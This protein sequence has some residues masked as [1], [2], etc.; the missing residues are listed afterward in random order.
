MIANNKYHIFSDKG[1]R[2]TN[3]DVELVKINLTSAGY[4]DDQNFAPADF[5][6]VCDGHGGSEVAKC[7]APLLLKC[8]M[9]SKKTYPLEDQYIMRVC[10]GIQNS[11]IKHSGKIAEHC[12]STALVVILYID[13]NKKRQLQIINIGDCRAVLS[14][15]CMAIPLTSDHKPS[16]PK[17][18]ERIR[19]VNL[20]YK[21]NERI[22]FSEGDFR[23]GDLSVSRSF[24][25]IDNTPYV[26]HIPDIYDCALCPNDEFLIMACDGVWDVL[27]SEEA[28]HFVYDHYNDNS[29]NL[30]NIP[31]LYPPETPYRTKNIAEKL[32]HYALARG[33]QDNISVIIIFFG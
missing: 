5:F 21:T 7:V 9:N 31:G 27:G 3:E 6:V 33:S 25:D 18:K 23:I 10:H 32:A 26:T 14:R 17:E 13:A 12:G 4:R 28:V 19:R 29:T 11:L 22:H 1:G 20:K 24:G 15:D 30:Y 8:L 16:W 2:R